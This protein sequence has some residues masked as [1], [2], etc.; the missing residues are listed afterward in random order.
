MNEAELFGQLLRATRKDRKLRLGE[1]A[2]KVEIGIKHLGR[3]ER[4]EKVPSFELIIAL[5]KALNASPATFF[6]FEN[7]N[8]DARFL[9][10]QL[11]ELL[12]KRDIKQLRRAYRVLQ[13][14]L[15][16]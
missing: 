6:H 13:A 12:R 11:E 9:T 15:E 8:V 10:Q 16:A 4:G 3:I 2:E 5:A 1:L 14:T 7:A